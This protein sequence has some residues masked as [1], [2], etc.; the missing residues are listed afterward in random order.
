MKLYLLLILPLLAGCTKDIATAKWY[1]GQEWQQWRGAE[2]NEIQPLVNPSA[3]KQAQ[4]IK[5]A[6]MNEAENRVLSYSET[7]EVSYRQCAYTPNPLT[8]EAPQ[9]LTGAY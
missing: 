5:D 7:A 9:R 8:K 3:E 1:A 4:I 2:H 6:C